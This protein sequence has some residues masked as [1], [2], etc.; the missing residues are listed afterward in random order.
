MSD[1]DSG[2]TFELT[3]RRVLGGALTVGAASAA[4]GAGTF[5]LFSDSETSNN[6]SVQ[7]G[8]LDLTG[9]NSAVG[10]VSFGDVSPGSSGTKYI[11]LRNDGSVPGS[12]NFTVQNVRVGNS[13]SN[14]A[15]PNE[16]DTRVGTGRNDNPVTVAEGTPASGPIESSVSN[17]GGTFTFE[18]TAPFEVNRYNLVFDVTGDGYVDFNVLAGDVGE[19]VDQNGDSLLYKTLDSESGLAIS[20]S[21]TQPEVIDD[22]SIDT[23]DGTVSVDI[24]S[25]AVADGDGAGVGGFVKPADQGPRDP[26]GDGEKL[27][28]GNLA[29]DVVPGGSIY[30]PSFNGWGGG[31]VPIDTS[32]TRTLA[33][34]VDVR[35]AVTDDRSS[36][37]T[38]VSDSPADVSNSIPTAAALGKPSRIAR[39]YTMGAPL[40]SNTTRFLAVEYDLP[41]A[42]GNAVQGDKLQFDIE[43]EL[44]QA[45]E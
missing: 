17:S 9:G 16:F 39:E 41:F 33:D 7:A 43:A 42:A 31:L 30:G 1:D 35:L 38:L 28:K 4:T 45:T 5:A 3:R 21:D 19:D 2:T 36:D 40:G 34:V 27:Y 20:K 22:V 10:S 25:D 15:N 12:L 23:T 32:A 18:A 13:G 14:G 29:F 37:G 6:N 26:D 11:R 8:T 24:S 44:V